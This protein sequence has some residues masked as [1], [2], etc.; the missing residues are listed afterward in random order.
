MSFKRKIEAL[1]QIVAEQTLTLWHGGNLEFAQENIAHKGGRWEYGPGL[2][3]TTHYDTAR[4]YSKG[5]RKLYRVTVAKGVNLY[6]VSLPL[7]TVMAFVNSDVI[8]A[9]RKDIVERIDKHTKAGSINAE[10]FLNIIINESAIKNTNTD[11]LRT[12][13]VQ[14]G[15]DY[16][17]QD[18][19]FGTHERMLVLFNMKKIVNKE[20]VKPTEKVFDL[21][22]QWM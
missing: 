10:T 7:P 14:N 1:Y 15:I 16:S 8:K 5:S 11:R 22:T 12:F 21:P 17:I 19:A 6:D 20:I 4:K 13:F 3:L 9:K 2:Y 18:N